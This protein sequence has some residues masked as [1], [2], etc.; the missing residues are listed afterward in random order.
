M[1]KK[2]NVYERF[3]WNKEFLELGIYPLGSISWTMFLGTLEHFILRCV[4]QCALPS[5]LS[6]WMGCF[7]SYLAPT[8]PRSSCLCLALTV[9]TT[10]IRG[11]WVYFV[12]CPSSREHMPHNDKDFVFLFSMIHSQHLDNFTAQRKHLINSWW[13]NDVNS[14]STKVIVKYI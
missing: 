2:I 9:F 7:Y 12:H 5:L 1:R 14:Y 11:I 8:F 3:S 13:M 10:Y 4:W 6:Q